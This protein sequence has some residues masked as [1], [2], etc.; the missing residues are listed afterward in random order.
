M[1]ET[2]YWWGVFMVA[3]VLFSRIT[4]EKGQVMIPWMGVFLLLLDYD[5]GIHEEACF[6]FWWRQGKEDLI[7]IY[8]CSTHESASLSRL[9][10]DWDYEMGFGYVQRSEDGND[11]NQHI[12]RNFLYC[13]G[14][15]E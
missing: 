15:G 10:M 6:Q 2:R 7:Y 4:F 1:I 8:L 5:T 9:G 14:Y 3:R 12:G 13:K 11:K